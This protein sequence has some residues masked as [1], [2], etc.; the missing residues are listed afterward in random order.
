ML[1]EFCHFPIVNLSFSDLSAFHNSGK[2]TIFGRPVKGQ[3]L[4]YPPGALESLTLS[5]D[6]TRLDRVLLI[7][8]SG[9]ST[10]IDHVFLTK[11]KITKAKC[12]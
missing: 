5:A 10:R 11:S 7:I 3:E 4:G 2:I 6:S 12:I 9:S 1:P 8:A